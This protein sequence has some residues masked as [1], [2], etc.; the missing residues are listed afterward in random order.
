M[1]SHTYTALDSPSH[2]RIIILQP[3]LEPSS[4]LHI[5]FHQ[6]SLEELED[7]Y[8][9]VSYCWGADVRTCP[10][11]VSDSTK[12]MVT[13][14]LGLALR[15]FRHKGD[16][17][18][19]WADAACINQTDDEEKARQIPLMVRIFR[20]AKRVLSW[21]GPGGNREEKAIRSLARATRQLGGDP[22]NGVNLDE[23]EALL[24]LDY[25]QRL[26]IIQEI[27]FNIDVLLVCGA[28]E[29]SWIRLWSGLDVSVPY[30]YT[31]DED[32]SRI[33]R[34]VAKLKIIYDLWTHHSM[35]KSHSQTPW[36]V[37][38]TGILDIMTQF[39]E[40][41]CTDD[42][43]RFHALYS[44]A[45]DT[46]QPRHRPTDRTIQLPADYSFDV[47]ETYILLALSAIRAGQYGKIIKQA[48]IRPSSRDPD[49]PTWL[50]DW[51]VLPTRR[52]TGGWWS[53]TAQHAP[54]DFI[55]LAKVDGDVMKLTIRSSDEGN[56][57]SW[58]PH[59]IDLRVMHLVYDH[60]FDPNGHW[61]QEY[62]RQRLDPGG[63]RHNFGY[64]LGELLRCFTKNLVP[65]GLTSS[66][67]GRCVFVTKC[68][69]PEPRTMLG[70]GN[71]SMQVGDL[72]VVGDAGAGIHAAMVVRKSVKQGCWQIVGDAWVSGG[73]NRP[74]KVGFDHW[75]FVG[76][77]ELML[78]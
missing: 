46:G 48:A 35:K 65:P 9:A 72:I 39:A 4:D 24:S 22:L 74:L 49:W 7:D 58:F 31:Q 59:I 36:D 21:L 34:Q 15:K 10:L 41:R 47:Q 57:E 18:L 78:V 53:L 40:Y 75:G 23:V 61:D 25:F 63:D 33:G 77:P 50:P 26:W 62:L 55:M 12:V 30:H 11:H 54:Y 60:F 37:M 44:M 5:S 1:T 43:D 69:D 45:T 17:R 6:G 16:V 76:G 38:E 73:Q 68:G 32:S 52:S 64:E 14:N 71:A 67:E 28:A 19:L 56:P 8:E 13:A 66:M 51:R 29:I 2:I 27:V 20:G 70:I 42:R 3:S